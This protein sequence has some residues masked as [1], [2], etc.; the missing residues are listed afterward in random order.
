MKKIQILHLDKTLRVIASRR[1]NAYR[2]WPDSAKE[3]TVDRNPGG[4]DGQGKGQ[5]WMTT[6]TAVSVI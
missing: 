2:Q 5:L 3:E 4:L 1:K 6:L